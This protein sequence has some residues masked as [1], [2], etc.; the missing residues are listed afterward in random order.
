MKRLGLAA[1][2]GLL[3]M[4]VLVYLLNPFD[5]PTLSPLA[6]LAGV[7]LFRVPG[8]AM[9][10]TIPAG[11][12][13]VGCFPAR[14]VKVGRIVLYTEPSTQGRRIDGSVLPGLPSNLLQIK[15]V[16]ALGGS[17]IEI[18]EAE[19]QLDGRRLEQFVIGPDGAGPPGRFA[20]PAGSVFVLG[21]HLANSRDS[22][23]VGF[24]PLD[25]VVGTVCA[26]L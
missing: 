9:E 18:G 24:I 4:A 22:R 15:R 5:A 10:P 19:I 1:L 25:H 17:V 3:G 26:V 23:F 6:R 2:V 21:D 14:G 16:A 20:V 7:Q 12:L 8:G 13:V 11:S